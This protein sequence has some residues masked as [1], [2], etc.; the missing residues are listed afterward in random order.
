[1]K[2]VPVGLVIVYLVS[3]V[4]ALIGCEFYDRHNAQLAI[5]K[6]V[7][8]PLTTI[9]LFGFIGRPHGRFQ[10]G[11]AL[12]IFFSLVGDVA[13]L[14]DG[15]A[16]FGIGLAGFLAAH[17]CYIVAFTGV[18]RW[19]A[20]VAVAAVIVA[21]ATAV[22]LT[23]VP[24]ATGVLRIAVTVYALALSTMVITASRTVDVLR[25]WGSPWPWFA[26]VGGFL[27]YV[28]DSSL[29]LDAFNQPI[30]R[31]WLLTIGVYWIGQ[32]GI[33]LAGRAAAPDQARSTSEARRAA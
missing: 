23:Q 17:I 13:L 5:L 6:Y 32:L 24:K 28:G 3:A 2:R 15:A 21:A 31:A 22:L 1:M 8:K 10:V 20:R 25:A 4:L 9:L 7:F 16:L 26:A 12:G 19:S 29:A 33:A 30:P 18:G 11:I 27:F 14:F